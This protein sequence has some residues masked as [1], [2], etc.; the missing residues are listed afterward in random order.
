M[1]GMSGLETIP[2]IKKVHPNLP[3]IVITA[4]T[5]AQTER[6]I[7]AQGIFYYFVKPFNME[8]MGQVVKSVLKE[9]N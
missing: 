7:R 9:K 3:I 2:L 4:D 8:E 5:S 1:A 6:K